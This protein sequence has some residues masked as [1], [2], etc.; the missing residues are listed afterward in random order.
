MA[1]AKL[2]AYVPEDLAD[3]VKRVAAVMDKSVSDVIEDAIARRF[4]SAGRE[5]EHAALLAKLDDIKG[6]LIGVERS[7][8]THFELTAHTARFAMSVAPDIPEPD[9]TAFNARGGERFRTMMATIVA[10][11]GDGRSVW[12]TSFP[13][14]PTAKDTANQAPAA[15]IAE[16]AHAGQP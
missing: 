12:K 16:P 15:S 10:R 8:E 7:Q 2:T 9:R 6:R 4:A 11:L 5:A 1:R 13:V 14:F 3:A